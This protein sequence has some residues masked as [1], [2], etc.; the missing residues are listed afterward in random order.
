MSYYLRLKFDLNSDLQEDPN[1]DPQI[2]TGHM[3]NLRRY[4]LSVLQPKS[5]RLLVD[6]LHARR[7][8]C[9]KASSLADIQENVSHYA[10]ARH[11]ASG[12]E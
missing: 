6:C 7:M 2:D 5:M 4:Y 12:N 3:P 8:N 10:S 11:T 1:A 9:G